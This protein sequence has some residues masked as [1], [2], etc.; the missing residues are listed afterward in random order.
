MK[1]N[2]VVPKQKLL[3]RTDQEPRQV[4]VLLLLAGNR[5]HEVVMRHDMSHLHCLSLLKS[6]CDQ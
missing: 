5:K 3:L 6:V 4:L 2:P 1:S